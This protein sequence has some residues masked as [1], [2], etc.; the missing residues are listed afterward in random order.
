M[1]CITIH[2]SSKY[3]L[4]HIFI[5]FIIFFFILFILIFYF[6]FGTK[7]WKIVINCH[8]RYTFG[9]Y[10]IYIHV[11]SMFKLVSCHGVKL[12]IILQRFV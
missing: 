2:S 3:L 8:D 6:P 11:P 10:I 12:S 4:G 9:V 5:I 1:S 7:K